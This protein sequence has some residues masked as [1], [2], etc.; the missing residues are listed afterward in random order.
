MISIALCVALQAKMEVKADVVRLRVQEMSTNLLCLILQGL[1]PLEHLRSGF[2][3]KA[4]RTAIRNPL[5][6]ASELF[7]HHDMLKLCSTTQARLLAKTLSS[8]VRAVN[9]QRSYSGQQFPW[10]TFIEVVFTL[11]HIDTIRLPSFP[12]ND[13]DSEESDEDAEEKEAAAGD[14]S[15]VPRCPHLRGWLAGGDQTELRIQVRTLSTTR[16][17]A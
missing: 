9:M 7:L 11:Q 14:P 17:Q 3:C 13:S 4:F 10:Q 8:R 2:V 1:D 16:R 15:V 12:W 5:S 6:W